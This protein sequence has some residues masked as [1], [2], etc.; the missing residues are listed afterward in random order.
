MARPCPSIR[1]RI[2]RQEKTQYV[3]NGTQAALNALA[4]VH[5]LEELTVRVQHAASW[6]EL[7]GLAI[8]RRRSPRRKGSS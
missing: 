1:R 7:L 8:P 4:D 5:R 3:P 6:Q 2:F